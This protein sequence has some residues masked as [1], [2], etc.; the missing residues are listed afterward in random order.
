MAATTDGFLSLLHCIIR[1]HQTSH[2]CAYR[3]VFNGKRPGH[4][5]VSRCPVMHDDA[6]QD[7][8]FLALNGL[9]LFS[10]ILDVCL[11]S[12]KSC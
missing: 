2:L 4:A 6:D 11:R 1:G 3:K 7:T 8:S 5:K 10:A 9:D 12:K